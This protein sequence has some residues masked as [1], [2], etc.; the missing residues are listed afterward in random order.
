MLQRLNLPDGVRKTAQQPAIGYGYH[1]ATSSKP[2]LLTHQ[3]VL[4]QIIRHA[5]QNRNFLRIRPALSFQRMIMRR[6]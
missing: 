1:F 3:A 6:Q 2:P 4:E 5:R